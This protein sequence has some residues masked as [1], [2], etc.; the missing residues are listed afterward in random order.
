M[1]GIELKTELNN[2]KT[3]LEGYVNSLIDPMKDAADKNQK[4]LDDLI[5]AQGEVH[6]FRSNKKSFGDAFSEAIARQFS[7]KQA[8][9]KAFQKDKDAK[10]SFTL[11]SVGTMTVTSNLTGDGQASYGNRQ[12]IVPNQKVN[13]RDIIPSVTSDTGIYVT[14]RETGGEGSIGEQ[15]EGEL[16]SQI[17]YDFTEIRN[18][19]GYVAGFARFSK[20]MM[21]Q[22]PWLQNT[23][24]RMLLRDFFKKENSKFYN[25]ITSGGATGVIN[26]VET[27][28]NKVIIDTLMA[29]LDQD[30]NNSFI[31]VRH[32]GVG[33]MLKLLYDNGMYLGAGSVVGTPQGTISIANT[34]VVGASWI[35]SDKV[36]II[37]NDFIERVETESLR[38]EFS[39]EDSDNFQRNLVT[40]RVE[41]FEDFNFLRT[42]A[43]SYFDLGNS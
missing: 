14:Y 5:A 24:T 29:R 37:D 42:D 2:L 11:K 31:L 16:K 12:G 7:E 35:A 30:F 41:C 6:F 23:L 33:R 28:D 32:N 13:I 9:I 20:Q 19:Q 18:V 34:P 25:A 22:L 39:Y 43:H 27:D 1:N 15:T 36:I 17:D 40:A 21:T 4:A 10:L 3:G 26:T 38:V 8:E